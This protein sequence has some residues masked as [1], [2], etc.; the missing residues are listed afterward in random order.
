MLHRHRRT[1]HGERRQSV[2]LYIRFPAL[3]CVSHM[4]GSCQRR[5]DRCRLCL[6]RV[7]LVSWKPR[8]FLYHNFLSLQEC[9]H[10]M[11]EAKP[12]VMI[13]FVPG[14]EFLILSHHLPSRCLLAVYSTGHRSLPS[15]KA[16]IALILACIC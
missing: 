15:L 14:E 4:R 3:L 5:F 16:V 8:A 13:P 9:Q 2:W 11:Q 12:M 7:E 10:I 1:L 6:G